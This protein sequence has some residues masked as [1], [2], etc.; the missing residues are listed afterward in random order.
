M[1]HGEHFIRCIRRHRNLEN[2]VI[3]LKWFELN[4]SLTVEPAKYRRMHIKSHISQWGFYLLFVVPSGD[5][6][7]SKN[8]NKYMYVVYNY[9]ATVT[10]Y[11]IFREGSTRF[12][13]V[14]GKVENPRILKYDD[15]LKWDVE[16]CRKYIYVTNRVLFIMSISVIVIFI[17]IFLAICTILMKHYLLFNSQCGAS[18][19]GKYVP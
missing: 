18:Q 2:S 19:F 7:F 12:L 1:H 10:E 15:S 17:Y 14:I 6:S 5:D 13:A 8:E 16:T 9:S 4:Y 3:Y 11:S